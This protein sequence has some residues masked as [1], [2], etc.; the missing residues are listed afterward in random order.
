MYSPLHSFGRP[1]DSLE[2]DSSPHPNRYGK[3]KMSKILALYYSTCSHREM[4]AHAVA[5]GPRETGA[6]VDVK[7]VSETASE[8]VARKR[9]FKLNQKAPVPS[10]CRCRSQYCSTDSVQHDMAR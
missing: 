4:M 2:P 6:M 7:R 1:S 8:E 9:H 3:S 10:V 5:A